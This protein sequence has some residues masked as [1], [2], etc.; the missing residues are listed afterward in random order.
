MSKPDTPYYKI[1]QML[2]VERD[3]LNIDK[4]SR[5]SLPGDDTVMIHMDD[6]KTVAVKPFNSIKLMINGK[7]AIV[8]YM[9]NLAKT[10]WPVIDQEKKEDKKEEDKKED[11]KKEVKKE[12]N[13]LEGRVKALE[14]ENKKLQ[15]M[16]D[17][18]EARID[19]L[20]TSKSTVTVHENLLDI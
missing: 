13:P 6:G 17:I 1:G 2:I 4:I 9:S 3:I 16:L 11:K 15:D 20:Q 5:I 18:L 8:D 19:S 14:V 7:E 10:I 12:K